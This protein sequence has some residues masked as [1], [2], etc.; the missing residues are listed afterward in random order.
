MQDDLASFVAPEDAAYILSSRRKALLALNLQSRVTMRLLRDG[1]LTP[2]AFA[3][4]QKTLHDLQDLQ[5]RV[6]RIKNFPYPRQ[7]AFINSLFV[8]I[9]CVLL[10]LGVIGEFAKLDGIV[11]GW[12]AGHMI[13]LGVPLSILIS[14]M[15]ASLDRVGEATENPFEGGANDVPITRI[16]GE[17]EADLR[18]ML[19][20]VEI[21]SRPKQPADI[22]M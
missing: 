6:E 16:C 17:I 3:D 18:E 21:A 14:W 4:L 7:H 12:A 10:P 22:A 2:S 5:S 11:D 9:L 19:G 20:E 1:T 13:W 15:Y 8:R